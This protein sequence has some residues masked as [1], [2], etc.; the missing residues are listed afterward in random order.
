MP[1]HYPANT[2]PFALNFLLFAGSVFFTV[3]KDRWIRTDRQ[4]MIGFALQA[5]LLTL[6][7]IFA[8]IGGTAGYWLVFITLVLD[9]GFSG[10]V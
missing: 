9:G 5:I 3:F 1:G 8:N 2:Y 6:V 10:I 7:P 4:I